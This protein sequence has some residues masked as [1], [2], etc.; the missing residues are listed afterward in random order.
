M[1]L[2]QELS[3]EWYSEKNKKKNQMKDIYYA[4]SCTISR[5][6]N[7]TE[8]NKKENLSLRTSSKKNLPLRSSSMKSLPL[9]GSEPHYD[10]EKWNNNF[11]DRINHNCYAYVLDDFVKDRPKRPQPGHRDKTIQTFRKQDYTREE[12]TRRAIYDNPSIYCTDPNAVCKKGYYKGVLVIDRYNNYHWIRQ[13][14]NGFWSHK[15]GQ[16]PVTNKDADGN[17]IV[18]PSKA[19]LIYD[20]ERKEYNLI[21]SEIGPYFC[22]PSKKDGPVKTKTHTCGQCGGGIRANNKKGICYKCK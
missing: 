21:Y 20:K 18:D 6:Y 8:Q 3:E 11:M 9:S 17:L 16:L 19:N 7:Q 2:N 14:S 13:D 10:P 1:S 15:P 12:M 5:N 22:I 4:D